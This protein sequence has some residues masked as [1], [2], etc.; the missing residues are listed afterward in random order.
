MTRRT[1]I[2]DKLVLCYEKHPVQFLRGN[3]INSVPEAACLWRPSSRRNGF[4]MH[5]PRTID[6][7]LPQWGVVALLI[8]LGLAQY[9]LSPMPVFYFGE[10]TGLEKA[11]EFQRTVE[12]YYAPLQWLYDHVAI[13]ESFYDAYGELFDDMAELLTGND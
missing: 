6:R 7:E 10:L 11:S 3:G 9:I 12:L 2:E 1:P 13:V 5:H 4:P 8:G